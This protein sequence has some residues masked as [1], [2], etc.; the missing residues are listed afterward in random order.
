MYKK[1]IS[2]VYVINVALQ[3]IFTLVWQIALGLGIGYLCV[4]FLSAPEW[5]YVP[6]ILAGVLTG[7]LSMVKF[8][9]GAMRSLDRLE[10]QHARDARARK[11]RAARPDG[12]ADGV[13]GDTDES[14]PDA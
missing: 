4:R 11:D 13:E 7:I 5:I 10:E 3:S 14:D 8:L 9:L 12:G 1:A 2:A 6:L